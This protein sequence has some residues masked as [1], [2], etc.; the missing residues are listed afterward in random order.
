MGTRDGSSG[1]IPLNLP[2]F[3]DTVSNIKF[4]WA[5][6]ICYFDWCI[7]GVGALA[8]PGLSGNWHVCI[9]AAFWFHGRRRGA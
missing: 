3:D 1:S 7:E 5:L 8:Y 4:F 2:V 6:G 9:D